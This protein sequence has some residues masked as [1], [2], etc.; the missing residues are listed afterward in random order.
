MPSPLKLLALVLVLLAALPGSWAS[1]AKVVA[2]Y[3]Y[4]ALD[5]NSGGRS[6][7]ISNPSAFHVAYLKP[8][9]ERWELKIGYSL[10]MA[11]FSGSDL[12]YGIDAGMNY[13]PLSSAMEEKL[14]TGDVTVTRYEV[15]MPF[16]GMSFNQRSFQSVRNS[17]AGFG[18]SAGSERYYSEK[19]NLRAELRYTSL[20][21]SNESEATETTLTFG[22]VFKL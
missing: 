9:W 17:Y 15:W 8:K 13:Y 20:G 10:L 11:D 12:G 6:S 14:T 4:F 21:G 7:S 3:G 1:D 2:S 18:V 16:V 5:A 19:I 22:V